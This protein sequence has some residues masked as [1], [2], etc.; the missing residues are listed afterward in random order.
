MHL[1]YFP[2]ALL[3]PVEGGPV[4]KQ[5]ITDL[6]SVARGS[7]IVV[8]DDYSVIPASIL[9]GMKTGRVN[10]IVPHVTQFFF[11]V[12]N[13]NLIFPEDIEKFILVSPFHPIDP[14]RN[15]RF[16]GHTGIRPAEDCAATRSQCPLNRIART[17]GAPNA[18][19][20]SIGFF[21][22]AV[23]VMEHLLNGERRIRNARGGFPQIRR[24]LSARRLKQNL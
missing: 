18:S 10:S 19:S 1:C 21:A 15:V 12:E 23:F 22:M 17:N 4:W 9:A 16:V 8:C 11:P 24:A 13:R 2:S 3:F 7:R 14:F 20:S 6:F 5:L